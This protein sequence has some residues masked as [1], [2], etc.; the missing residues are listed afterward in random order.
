M[1]V[2]GA[3]DGHAVDLCEHALFNDVV[4]VLA[5]LQDVVQGSPKQGPDHAGRVF[6]QVIPVLT[7]ELNNAW[8]VE[9]LGHGQVGLALGVLW[10]LDDVDNRLRQVVVIRQLHCL[11]PFLLAHCLSRGIFYKWNRPTFLHLIRYTKNRFRLRHPYTFGL[12]IVIR[13]LIGFASSAASWMA[14]SAA[15]FV[16]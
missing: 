3:G 4:V 6:C 14:A 16:E 12:S 15:V 5:V 9:Q 1:Q 11:L 7:L 10:P 8:A 2:N 13:T